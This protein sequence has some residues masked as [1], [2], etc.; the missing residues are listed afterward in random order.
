MCD[1]FLAKTRHLYER[2]QEKQAGPYRHLDDHRYLAPTHLQTKPTFPARVHLI[3]SCLMHG[4]DSL[5]QATHKQ[6]HFTYDVFNNAA[7]LPGVADIDAV[8]FQI[9]QLPL[10]SIIRE[11]MY[12]NLRFDEDDRYKSLFDEAVSSLKSNFTA[13]LKY[14]EQHKLAT[15]VLNFPV[16]QQD[17]MGRFHNRYSLKNMRYFFEELNRMLSELVEARQNAYIVDLDNIVSIFGKKYALEDSVTHFNHGAFLHNIELPPDGER[18]EPT[19]NLERMYKPNWKQIT[20]TIY[21]E[22]LS[23]WRILK[24]ENSV[25]IVIFDLDDTLWRGVA[26]EADVVDGNLT[27]GWPLGIAEALSY[28]WRRGVLV[29]LVSKNDFSNARKTWDVLYQRLFPFENFVVTKI[30]WRPKSDNIKEI[31]SEVN[32]L[33]QSALFVDDNPVERANVRSA[34]PDIRVLDAPVAEWRRILL[35]SP[36]TQQAHI[37][38]EAVARTAMIQAEI[39]READKA[40]MGSEDFLA[41]LGTKA[42]IILVKD[43][44]DPHYKRCFELI[45]KTNQYNT[46]GRRWTPTEMS[47]FL[48]DKG[49]LVALEVEDRYTNYGIVGIVVVH[50]DTIE[51]YVMSCR[52]LGMGV[53]RVAVAEAAS[54]MRGEGTAEVRALVSPTGRNHLCLSLFGDLGFVE[55]APGIWA[56]EPSLAPAGSENITVQAVDQFEYQ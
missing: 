32:L 15:F 5:L 16:P 54:R 35:W 14:N 40:S 48:N 26:A 41:S 49:C 28:L 43:D 11:G 6:T 56:L 9:V 50:G 39:V 45:N 25:K 17:F 44:R 51:Q 42:K 1:E 18:L 13:A 19:G 4:W 37:S 38:T 34:L 10:R 30:N 36:E 31:L 24:Q 33:P 52:V 23:M 3:G 7:A 12:M 55:V 2:Y 20:D 29:A 8:D 47:N 46:T 27:E 53:E 22:S 21:N